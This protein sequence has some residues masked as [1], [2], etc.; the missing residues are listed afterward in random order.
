MLPLFF[1][2]NL[3]PVIALARRSS[4]IKYYFHSFYCHFW[5]TCITFFLSVFILQYINSISLH[6]RKG[7]PGIMGQNHKKWDLISRL[8]EGNGKSSFEKTSWDKNCSSDKKLFKENIEVNFYSAENT[9]WW[10]Q[11]FHIFTFHY[12]NSSGIR[13][14]LLITILAW[15]LEIKPL[16]MSR[17]KH[18]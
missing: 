6:F 17:K 13:L 10:S 1:W 2:R 4:G 8:P 14:I 11:V 7:L 9:S 16:I 3:E 12:I 15:L 5:T 18:L